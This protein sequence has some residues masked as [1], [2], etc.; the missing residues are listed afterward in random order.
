[1]N[2]H[3]KPI[4]DYLYGRFGDKYRFVTTMP[5]PQEL[6]NMGYKNKDNCP[7]IIPLY[8]EKNI[9]IVEKLVLEADVVIMGGVHLEYLIDLRVKTGK[10]LLFYSERWHKRFRSY[11]ILPLR[12]INGY[13]YHRFTRFNSLNTYLLCASSFVPNDCRWAFAFKDKTY[14]W[15]YFPPFKEIK[16]NEILKKKNENQF[17]EVLYVARSLRWKHPELAIKA[18]QG[19]YEQGYKVRLTMIGGPYGDNIQSEKVF[20]Y[21]KKQEK[22]TPNCLQVL[23]PVDNQTVRKMMLKSDIFLFTSDRNEGWGASLNEAMSS[24]CACIVSD[25]IGSSHFLI[26]NGINGL[27]FKNKN[28]SSLIEQL[29]N[30]FNMDYRNELAINAYKTM[31]NEW[32]PN[33][34]AERLVNLV[35]RL[36]EGKDT[37]YESG[38][39]SKAY[40]V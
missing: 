3:Q 20:E 8:E 7:Y 13:V 31:I 37:L 11:L 32:Q 23:G 35:H 16:I 17:V 9:G 2:H 21:C 29:R 18:V 19:L 24:G 30:A 40:P 12:Y 14:K 28:L 1:M 22:M 6:L 39:C 36:L 10:L 4:A 27:L 15:G 33:V 25:A 5:I 26:N 38:P 34:A